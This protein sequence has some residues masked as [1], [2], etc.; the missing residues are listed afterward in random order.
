MSRL[1]RFSLLIAFFF[2]LD[3]VAAFVRQAVIARQF[4][5]GSALDTFNVANNVPDLLYAVISGGALAI[6]FIP[7][8]TSTLTKDGRQ[9][10]WDL[11]SKVINLFF[12]VT[13]GLSL[14]VGLAAEPLVR[15]AIAPGFS[16]EQQQV[17]INLMRIDLLATLIFSVSGLAMA[18]LQAN[19]HFFFPA[20]APIFYNVGQIIGALFLAPLKGYVIAGVTLPTM[21]LGVYGLAAGVI[22]GALLHLLI[23]VP[24]L[25]R[26]QFHWTPGFGLKTPQVQQVLR[27][28]GPRVITVLSVQMIFLIRDNLA[29]RLGAGAVSSLTYGWMLQQL[30]ET[31]IATAIGTAMLPALSELAAKEDVAGFHQGLARAVRVL[32]GITLPVGVIMGV[33][34]GPV[35]SAVF[36]AGGKDTAVLMW[37]TRGFLA[38]LVGHSLMEVAARA[39][40]AR[41]DA[42]TPLIAALA[43]LVAYAIIGSLLYQP[44]GVAGI[45]LTDAICFTTQA[46]VLLFVL[47]R[48]LKVSFYPGSVLVRAVLAGAVG[49]GAVWAIQTLALA[50]FNPLVGSLVG[51]SVGGLLIVPFIWQELKL[52][53][54]L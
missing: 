13:A 22:L 23:Q 33:G 52:L 7:V 51:M 4:G 39:F 43:N 38:G 9:A 25:L 32:V 44:L 8:L 29:S 18:G 53:V 15:L 42:R 28:M 19:Q 54:K 3:K 41:Q 46:V 1:T 26:Y 48:K 21:G 20:M 49:G 11:F 37:V 17:T 12:L 50:R 30:P 40:Y 34:L 16:P 24:G 10:A 36:G 35:V 14:L 6:A 31:L 45:S 5:F 47:G 2:A 27:L